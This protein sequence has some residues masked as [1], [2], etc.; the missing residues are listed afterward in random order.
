MYWLKRKKP[1][2]P[3]FFFERISL[4]F[5]LEHILFT[6]F[7][8]SCVHVANSPSRVTSLSVCQQCRDSIYLASVLRNIFR[9][10]MSSFHSLLL[11]IK[12]LLSIC[13]VSLS[14]LDFRSLSIYLRTYAKHRR[15]SP[16]RFLSKKTEFIFTYV[17]H[18]ISATS[19]CNRFH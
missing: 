2:I 6:W 3:V 15:S 14:L 18:D 8:I 12:L 11:L 19:R 5:F 16:I 4:S 9:D 13:I 7:C 17:V 10:A 1:L